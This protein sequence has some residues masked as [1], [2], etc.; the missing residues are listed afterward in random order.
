MTKRN[1]SDPGGAGS[2]VLSDFVMCFGKGIASAVSAAGAVSMTIAGSGDLDIDPDSTGAAGDDVGEVHESAPWYG[3]LGIVG[4]QL[5]P[6]NNEH[7]EVLC[8]RT[9]DGLIPMAVRDVRLRM[10]G[11]APSEGTLAFVGYGGGFHSL[12][13]VA[14]GSDPSGGGTIHMVYCPYDFDADGVAQKAHTLI[15]D[16][17]TGNQSIQLIHGDGM[18]ITMSGEGDKA[19]LLKNASGDANLRLDDNGITLTADTIVLAGNVII[20]DAATM[21]TALPLL[22]GAS[23]PPCS[24]LYVAP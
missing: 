19:L 17:S 9:G 11:S 2:Q 24:K 23:S 5:P 12:T 13:P 22:A 14:D 6:L 3:A 1:T 21:A 8:V 20:G 18:A 4:R 15:M 16:P 7:L 10:A